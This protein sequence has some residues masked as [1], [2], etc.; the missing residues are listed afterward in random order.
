MVY[1]SAIMI[2][3]LNLV[4]HLFRTIAIA[5]HYQR[6]FMVCVLFVPDLFF[7]G[8]RVEGQAGC[9]YPCMPALTKF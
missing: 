7:G 5:T 6:T 4:L 3:M 8:H 2:I 1:S 9:T